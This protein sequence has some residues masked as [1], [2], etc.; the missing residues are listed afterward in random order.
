[1]FDVRAYLHQVGAWLREERVDLLPERL[2]GRPSDDVSEAKFLWDTTP[3][4]TVRP[5]TRLQLGSFVHHLK[6]QPGLLPDSALPA[7]ISRIDA[8]LMQFD[9]VERP[10]ERK[11]QNILGLPLLALLA[12]LVVLHD[13]NPPDDLAVN[14]SSLYRRLIDL[15]TRYGGNV[16]PISPSAPKITGE[17]LRD[18]LQRTA[19][20]MTLRGTE[21]I[22]YRE[23]TLRLEASNLANPETAVGGAIVANQIAKLMLSFFFNTGQ[24]GC[25]FTHKSF[26]EYL[27]AEAIVEAL[28]RNAAL[29]GSNPPRSAY[30]REFEDGDPRHALAEELGLMLAPQWPR[31]ET[32]RIRWEVWR[33]VVWLISWEV[34]R[35]AAT[36]GVRRSDEETA[37]L[38]LDGWEVV[39]DR[40]ADLWDWWA[41][42]VHMRP[43]PYRE[44]GKSNIT[45]NPPYALRLAEQIPPTDL[46]RGSFPEP[47]CLTTLDAHLGDALLRLNCALHFQ[48]NI[49]TGWL[50]RPS[51][52]DADLAKS[53]WE[54]AERVLDGSR[55]YQTR[56]TQGDR[57]W[58]AFAPSEPQSSPRVYYFK[59]YIG[60]INGPSAR[61]W[62][63]LPEGS[64]FSGVDFDDTM[65]GGLMMDTVG[66]EYARLTHSVLSDSVMWSCSF[67]AAFAQA[68]EWHSCEIW[69]SSFDSTYLEDADFFDSLIVDSFPENAAIPPHFERAF[70]GSQDDWQDDYLPGGR[71]ARR[72]A[73]RPRRLKSRRGKRG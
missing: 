44:K 1:V 40:L 64:D 48:I 25:E 2:T 38:S 33:H 73:E 10:E 41:E 52:S 13:K 58:W 12:I 3:V 24:Q 53:I 63:S 15:T 26:R 17:E 29:P 54:G 69:R 7:A 32:W 43:Q 9:P 31:W 68:S 19:A 4:L 37:P 34:S 50:D 56:I 70:V 49:A 6:A 66:F 39:R 35:A 11:D 16:E 51:L 22:P 36:A 65:L 57:I 28:K 71:A 5:F 42:G 8:L 47:V 61:G 60:R 23:L 14:R 30:W 45:F 46:P 72:S 21:H 62:A 67:N 20:A 55:R 59:H 27:F 18:L